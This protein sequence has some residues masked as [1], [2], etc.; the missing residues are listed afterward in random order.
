VTSSGQSPTYADWRS[1]IEAY[2]ADRRL[3]DPDHLSTLEQ[4]RDAL[5]AEAAT[6]YRVGGRWLVARR[7]ERGV[8][9]SDFSIKSIFA[10]LAKLR[11]LADLNAYTSPFLSN[12]AGS[13][14]NA[15]G[16]LKQ[17][18]ALDTAASYVDGIVFHYVRRRDALRTTKHGR[19][20]SVALDTLVRTTL[21]WGCTLPEIARQ[22]VDAG[23]RPERKS[24]RDEP[25][26]HWVRV[27]K[28]ARRRVRRR[29]PKRL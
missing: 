1:L 13:V 11:L 18:F 29:V 22:L 3:Q 4:M 19:P 14:D 2:Q 28:R 20:P 7:L 26:A 24:T 12:L 25:I 10:R 5:K 17:A 16:V 6:M 23:V 21:Q 8:N 9:L 15:R 27:P